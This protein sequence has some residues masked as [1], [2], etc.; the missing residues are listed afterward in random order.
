VTRGSP[1]DAGR[2]TRIAVKLN[3]LEVT[4]VNDPLRTALRRALADGGPRLTALR[5]RPVPG[6]HQ[7]AAVREGGPG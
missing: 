6:W 3:P 4:L 1:Q 7:G 5:S 2:A